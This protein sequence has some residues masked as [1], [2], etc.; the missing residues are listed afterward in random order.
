MICS[1]CG[2]EVESGMRFCS[3][4]GHQMPAESAMG[5]LQY[6]PPVET[7]ES[8]TTSPPMTFNTLSIDN[9]LPGQPVSTPIESQPT[10]GSLMNDFV[11]DEDL[12]NMAESSPLQK[13]QSFVTGESVFEPLSTPISYDHEPRSQN[14]K[15][16]IVAISIAAVFCVVGIFVLAFYQQISMAI[17]SPPEYYVNQEYVVLKT[18]FES[19]R[20]N[21]RMPTQDVSVDSKTTIDISGFPSEAQAVVDAIESMSINMKTDYLVKGKYAK[22]VMSVLMQGNE[23]FATDI[24]MDESHM[25]VSF[26]GLADGMLVSPIGLGSSNLKPT[27]RFEKIAGISNSEFSL[28]AQTF[29]KD[30]FIDV[31]PSS[32]ITKGNGVML[33]QRCKTVTFDFNKESLT[34]MANGLANYMEKNRDALIPVIS[35]LIKYQEQATMGNMQQFVGGTVSYSSDIFTVTEEFNKTLSQLKSA[36]FPET[37]TLYTVYYNKKGRIISRVVAPDDSGFNTLA[38]NTYTQD[39]AQVY[40]IVS[41]TGAKKD[42]FTMKNKSVKDGY[43]GTVDLSVKQDS[44]DVVITGSY[45]FKHVTNGASP[46]IAGQAKLEVEVDGTKLGMDLN[47]Q[48][49]AKDTYKTTVSM[50]L[51]DSE[52]PIK[53]DVNVD[54][55]TSDKVTAQKVEIPT[56]STMSQEGIEQVINAVFEKLMQTTLLQ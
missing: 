50:V 9:A 45:D 19:Y 51:D 22:A 35:N 10:T 8:P 29:F 48:N 32:A 36:V 40:E 25:G 39:D 31:F 34:A 30:S 12:G 49:T 28:L 21:V 54:V 20:S 46:A 18:I 2:K 53:L 43:S 23:L 33:D 55:T 6:K 5:G 44:T 41:T 13:E 1:N 42:R 38:L 26:P 11:G 16:V 56:S 47:I 17:S 15:A 52:M 4:C 24:D 7:D 3:E 37:S 27:E 14:N